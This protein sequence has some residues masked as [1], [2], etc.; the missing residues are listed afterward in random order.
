MRCAIDFDENKPLMEQEV[1]TWGEMQSLEEEPGYKESDIKDV[2]DKM[3]FMGYKAALDD[4]CNVLDNFVVDGELDE[5]T[6]FDIQRW[7]SGELCMNL[8]S[9]LDN[10]YCEEDD[11]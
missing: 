7:L 4:V 9:I 1:R 10:E 11:E 8:F 3:Y 2:K 6:S 5:E